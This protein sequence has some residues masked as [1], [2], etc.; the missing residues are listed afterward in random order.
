MGMFRR[1]QSTAPLDHLNKMQAELAAKNYA[2]MHDDTMDWG[3]G[4]HGGSLMDI[5]TRRQLA[6]QER[7]EHLS[8]LA[9]KRQEKYWDHEDTL[10]DEAM[11][12]FAPEALES[13]Y[14]RMAKEDTAI[15][16]GNE[17][18]ARQRRMSAMGVDPSS[19]R[20]QAMDR[21]AG[22][23]E[24]ASTAGAVNMARRSAKTDSYDKRLAA[25]GLGSGLAGLSIGG[26]SASVG[27]GGGAVGTA[28]QSFAGSANIR[29]GAIQ[30]TA[31]AFKLKQQQSAQ[32]S[33]DFGGIVGM[34]VRAGSA[35]ATGG[36]SEMGR[37]LG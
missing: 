8:G 19:G 16:F 35:Y 31:Q 22:L 24:A 9:A 27:A 33:R 37:G 4:D 30:G 6:A 1:R 26:S 28:N 12:D 25:L 34:G 23:A 5:I 3:Q 17:R 11:T 36:L 20:G 21:T 18:A 7:Q 2:W 10:V 32:R 14:V 15:A 29:Q 13:E